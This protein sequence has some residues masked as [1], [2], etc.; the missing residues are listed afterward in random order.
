M[1][2]HGCG[3]IEGTAVHQHRFHAVTRH[4]GGILAHFRYIWRFDI[5]DLPSCSP[6]SL[7]ASARRGDALPNVAVPTEFGRYVALQHDARYRRHVPAT[8]PRSSSDA[9]SE[10]SS[11]PVSASGVLQRNRRRHAHADPL[12]KKAQASSSTGSS[13]PEM[14]PFQRM[15]SLTG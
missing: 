8:A 1:L 6:F 4:G 15:A 2:Q 3:T 12:W 9:A 7:A 11:S 5:Q 10:R 14:S 13:I